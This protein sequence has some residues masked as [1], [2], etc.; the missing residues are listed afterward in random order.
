MDGKIEQLVCIKFCTK[1]GKSNTETL[2]MLREAFGED[3]LSRTAVFK[4]HPL[5]KT[6]RVSVKDDERSRRPSTNKTTENVEEF[7]D[8]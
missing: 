4:W 1:L 8:C 2:E 6:G 3:S 7:R 5:F